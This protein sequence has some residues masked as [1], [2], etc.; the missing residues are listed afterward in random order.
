MKG[1][2]FLIVLASVFVAVLLVTSVTHALGLQRPQPLDAA[3]VQAAA[4]ETAA[5]DSAAQDGVSY[6]VKWSQR[7]VI[8]PPIH[9]TC[10]YGWDENSILG[11]DAADA[12]V[13]ADDWMCEDERP[14]SDIHWWGSY[15]NW[16]VELAPPV[17]PITFHIGIWTD[18]VTDPFGF[19]HPGVLLQEWFV[20]R[21]AVSE[22]LAGCD[23]HPDF[24]PVAEACFSYTY[25]IPT[26]QWFYQDPSGNRVYWLSLAAIYTAGIQ[27]I[28]H[29][30]G[31]KTRPHFFNDDAVRI[32]EP[33]TPTVGGHF[34]LGEPIEDLQG[35]TWDL[36]FELTSPPLD[37]GDAPD[38][39]YPTLLASNGAR[40]SISPMLYLGKH[41]DGEADGQPTPLA[42][43]DDVNPPTGLDDEDGVSFLSALV[44]GW[45]ATAAVIAS[46]PGLLNAWIDFDQ[47][48]SWL[49]P[50]E[51]IVTDT[52]L[53][54]GGAIVTFPVPGWA[55]PAPTC[56]RFRFSSQ[57]GLTPVGL[58]PDGEVED[59][60]VNVTTLQWDKW[61][62]E[63]PWQEGISITVE[64][65]DTIRVVDVVNDF[66]G[67]GFN[68]EEA[69]NPRQL[70]LTNYF[71]VSPTPGSILVTPG[72]LTWTVPGAGALQVVTLTKLFHVEPCTWT[73]TILSETLFGETGTSVPPV[74][75]V[76]IVKRPPDLHITAVA[77]AEARAGQ[78]AAFTLIYS[79][80]G[81]REDRI[82]I[83]NTFPL[84]ARFAQST[85][86]PD[87]WD[88][89]GLW[90]RWNVGTL[91]GGVMSRIMVTVNVTAALPTSSTVEIW[92]GIYD[93]VDRLMDEVTITMHVL[94]AF[95]STGSG[96]WND[97]T[98][99]GGLGVPSAASDVTVTAGTRVIVNAPTACTNLYVE[100]GAELVI[101][102]PYTLTVEGAVTNDGH[103]IMARTNASPTTFDIENADGSQVKYHGLVITPTTG[104][105]GLVTVTIK[106]NQSC[107][108]AGAVLRCY[109]IAPTT[110]T[111]ATVQFYYRSVETNTNTS[112]LAWHWDASAWDGLP[113]TYGGSGDA[114]W[115]QATNVADYSPFVLKD[116]TP[117]TVALRMAS[118]LRSRQ[119]AALLVLVVL[120]FVVLE[121]IYLVRRGGSRTAPTQE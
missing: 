16:Q 33:V 29:P 85:P 35:Q 38:P 55:V 12:P 43:G 75:P 90:A 22:T 62:G 59:Y 31:W 111:T 86:W 17:A 118:V 119:V 121:L 69:W 5:Q 70:S 74:R 80:T 27:D 99:W 14:V 28:P 71:V 48:G 117:T 84:S 44:P 61:I 50:G 36:A 60:V 96:D 108:V 76:A 46:N 103:L 83:T 95:S 47:N 81:G 114:M 67:W 53:M 23:V 1:S 65:S 2:R 58:A 68:L 73:R 87:A 34:I 94:N 40:H 8:S 11:V 3:S 105:M 115:V 78:P 64:T 10:F 9:L 4:Q 30:W 37:Y 101:L 107:G 89:K 51:Q 24:S 52:T 32:L 77:P 57:A 82:V 25:Q 112:P 45:K 93:H 104:A 15:K 39:S 49:D 63:Q 102:D 72:R 120:A 109:E 54:A 42:D 92:D 100:P 56:A 113:S 18:I 26:S 116:G 91:T 6:T 66:M 110:Q 88:T 7:P 20:E 97:A 21:A 79:N 98:T 41:V 106:G 19:S 13:M